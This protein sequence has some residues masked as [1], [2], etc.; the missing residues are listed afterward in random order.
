MTRAA[1]SGRARHTDPAGPAPGTLAASGPAGDPESVAR[2]ICLDALTANPRSRAELAEKLR[3]RGVP[4]DA[5]TTVLDRFT[6]VGLI[7]DA[8]FAAAWVESRQRSRGLSRR[9]LTTE[10]YRKGVERATIAEAVATVDPDDERA[11]ARALVEKRLRS[12]GG[13]ATDVKQRRLVSMLARK[14][15][16]AGLAFAVVREAIGGEVAELGELGDLGE[17]GEGV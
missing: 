6:E 13:L 16:S 14:G 11:A 1:R 4:D 17:R 5:A 9:A 8:A 3:T 7:D 12:M 10:L 2:T 15:Y